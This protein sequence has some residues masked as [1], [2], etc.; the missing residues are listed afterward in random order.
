MAARDPKFQREALHE[1]WELAR[2]YLP[3]RLTTPRRDYVFCRYLEKRRPGQS[4]GRW[5]PPRSLHYRLSA[6]GLLFDEAGRVLMVSD[7][8]LNFGWNL[9]GGGVAKHE[10]LEQGLRREFE[11]ETGLLVEVGAA[12]ANSDNFCIMPTGQ[13]VHAVLHFYLVRVVGGQL[14]PEGNGFD[15][16]RVAYINL[17]TVPDTELNEPY[18]M[19]SL[20]A[21]S[22]AATSTEL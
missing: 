5:L 21:L 11:E 3:G 1:G 14:M 22:R 12:V 2:D 10:T 19:R 16:S 13:P 8:A 4:R 9:P 20:A 15:T 17:A 7:P 18:L 6:Y